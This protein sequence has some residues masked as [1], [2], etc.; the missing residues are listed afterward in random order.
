MTMTK[1][2][3]FLGVLAFAGCLENAEC[4]ERVCGVDV[5]ASLSTNGRH[6]T[7]CYAVADDGAITTTLE[8]DHGD[9]FY[10]CTDSPGRT[11]TEAT[12]NAMFD[13]CDVH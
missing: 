10:G 5:G 12:V 8:D 11:C 9:E 1:K 2:L 13:Y 3:V 4:S 6:F 7:K